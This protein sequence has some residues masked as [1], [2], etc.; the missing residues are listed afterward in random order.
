[1]KNIYKPQ[2]P[3]FTPINV[4]EIVLEVME[5]YSTRLTD[6]GIKLQLNL[7]KSGATA[8]IDETALYTSLGNIILNSIDAMPEGGELSITTVNRENHLLLEVA[9][10]GKGIKPSDLPKIFKPFF[11]TKTPEEGTGLGLTLVKEAVEISGGSISVSSKV[12]QGTKV[13][14]SLLKN[15]PVNFSRRIGSSMQG[16]FKPQY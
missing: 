14:I 13:M 16:F 8:F 10:N 6:A 9:D 7:E 4:N 1:M 3:D 11:T 2:E 5:Q 12:G 15:E